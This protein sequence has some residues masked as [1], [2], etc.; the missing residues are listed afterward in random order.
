MQASAQDCA[1]V[2]LALPSE[3]TSIKRARDAVAELAE[4]VGAPVRDVKLAVSEAV[5]NSVIHGF[6]GDAEGTI[7]ITARLDRGRLLVVIADNGVGMKPNLDSPGLGVGISLIT[8]LASDVR[9]DSGPGGLT[10]SMTFPAP[11]AT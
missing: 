2:R 10:V 9:F 6:R 4:R 8:T 1:E 3:A 11:A 5:S 7:N